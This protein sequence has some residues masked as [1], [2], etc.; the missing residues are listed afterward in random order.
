LRLSITELCVEDQGGVE[1][2]VEVWLG[3]GTAGTWVDV[4]CSGS[5]DAGALVIPPAVLRKLPPTLAVLDLTQVNVVNLHEGS[6]DI[7]L[8]AEYAVATVNATLR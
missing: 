5:G 2:V 4:L 6:W 7:G 3:D 8:R 1:N